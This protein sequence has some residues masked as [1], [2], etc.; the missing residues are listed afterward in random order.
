M[1]AGTTV[2]MMIVGMIAGMIVATTDTNQ[3]IN[4]ELRNAGL[5]AG[6]LFVGAALLS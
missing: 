5:R 2:G 4:S 6:V 1:I 3:A